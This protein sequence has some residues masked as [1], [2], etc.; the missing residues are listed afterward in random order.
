MKWEHITKTWCVVGLSILVGLWGIAAFAEGGTDPGTV[1]NDA[2]G[3][4]KDHTS[5]IFILT[6]VTGLLKNFLPKGSKLTELMT[7][8]VPLLL[9]VAFVFLGV[10]SCDAVEL[11]QKVICGII[12][13]L[14]ASGSYRTAKVMSGNGK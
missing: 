11:G 6:V 10:V 9:G 13:G 7:P 14:E 8:V 5:A 1:M 4:L 2:A 3:T 12:F